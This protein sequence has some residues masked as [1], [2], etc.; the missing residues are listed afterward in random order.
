MTYNT[1]GRANVYGDLEVGSL[2]VDPLIV[3]S[4][5]LALLRC[6]LVAMHACASSLH[7]VVPAQ[8]TELRV[9]NTIPIA[10]I[11]NSS[12]LRFGT[13]YRRVYSE[14]PVQRFNFCGSF[15][16]GCSL[17]VRCKL[18]VVSTLRVCDFYAH[19]AAPLWPP[20]RPLRLQECGCSNWL[21]CFTLALMTVV[22]ALQVNNYMT[23]MTKTFV[24]KVSRERRSTLGSP[25]TPP[26]TPPVP[27]VYRSAASLSSAGSTTGTPSRRSSRQMRSR[28]L[29]SSRQRQRNR[30]LCCTGCVP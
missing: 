29:C 24:K 20:Q 25:P 9:T 11:P 26:Y 8:V 7:R 21:L 10:F 4:C 5:T 14:N 23:L 27:M 13:T 6:N 17:C 1:F 18:R 2:C 15:M 12:G 16:F 3:L 28:T 22:R 19:F 30:Q